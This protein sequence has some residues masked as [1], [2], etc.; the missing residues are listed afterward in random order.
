MFLEDL[1]D[2]L[3]PF[4]TKASSL[5]QNATEKASSLDNYVLDSISDSIA[6]RLYAWLSQ[7]P[8]ISWLVNHPVISLIGS[9]I[10]IILTVRLLLTIYRAIANIIDRMWLWILRSPW[11]LLR[12][13]FGWEAK[14]EIAPDSTITN[15]EATNNPEQ[16]QEIVTRLD[17]IQLQQEQILQELAQLKQQ[18]H[19]STATHY[20]SS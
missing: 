6:S 8:F 1:A 5:L 7:H 9:L 11:L 20:I 14:P 3:S 18:S 17:K 19:S 4:E 13:L 15:Y 10:T 16:L 12:F 2:K